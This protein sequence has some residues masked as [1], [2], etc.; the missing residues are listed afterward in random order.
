MANATLLNLDPDALITVTPIVREADPDNAG[1][2]IIA[3]KGNPTEISLTEFAAW[4]LAQ[5]EE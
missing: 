2:F 1:E 5:A 3:N 4:V